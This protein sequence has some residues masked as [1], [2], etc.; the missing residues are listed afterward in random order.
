MKDAVYVGDPLVPTYCFHG[1]DI[2]TT[3]S[4]FYNHQSN[5]P[6]EVPHEILGAGDGTVI[7][8]SLKVTF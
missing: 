1:K 8:R 6:D 3:A 4:Y 5:F 2:P 7:H